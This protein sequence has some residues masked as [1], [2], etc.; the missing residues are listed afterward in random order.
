MWSSKTYRIRWGPRQFCWKL[1]GNISNLQCPTVPEFSLCV[2][3][4][5]RRKRLLSSNRHE[6]V[7]FRVIRVHLKLFHKAWKL[8]ERRNPGGNH[9]ELRTPSVITGRWQQQLRFFQASI[10]DYLTRAPQRQM[11]AKSPRFTWRYHT[12]ISFLSSLVCSM[13]EIMRNDLQNRCKTAVNFL[14]VQ[15]TAGDCASNLQ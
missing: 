11:Q 12:P 3:I 9:T 2:R 8:S 6:V 4:R 14:V 15:P 1:D 10:F 13:S 7:S 5:N